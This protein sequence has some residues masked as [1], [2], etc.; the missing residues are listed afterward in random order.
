MDGP[1]GFWSHSPG[2]IVAILKAA[3]LVKKKGTAADL[4]R[5]LGGQRAVRVRDRSRPQG[6]EAP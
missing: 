6:V 3:G 2:Q 5:M 1:G 4:V